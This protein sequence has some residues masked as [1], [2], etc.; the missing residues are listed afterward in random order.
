MMSRASERSSESQLGA[1]FVA[2]GMAAS[3]S[4]PMS[5]LLDDKG[6][7]PNDHFRVVTPIC[8]L[9]VLRFYHPKA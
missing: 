9:N 1:R 5:L 7:A 6:V 3:A 4:N 2:L 8:P